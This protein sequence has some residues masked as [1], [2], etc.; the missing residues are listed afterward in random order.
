MDAHPLSPYINDFLNR[1]HLGSEVYYVGQLCDVWHMSTPQGDG[2]AFHLVCNGEAWVH[3]Q[4]GGTPIHLQ[5]GDIAFFPHYAAHRFSGKPEIPEQDFDYSCPALV[6]RHAPGTGMLCGHLKLP[7]HIRRLLLASFPEFMLIRPDESQTGRQLR[8]LI[9]L[10]SLEAEHNDIGVTAVLNHLSD[11]LFLLIIRHT[12]QALPHLSPLLAALSDEH[13]RLAMLPFIEQP[14]ATWSVESLA[15]LACL[16]RSTYTERFSRMV[17]M[18]PMEFVTNWRMQLAVGL[19]T[20]GNLSILDVALRC[21]YESDVAFRKA[22]KRV[23]GTTPGK[24][25][26]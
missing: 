15:K 1:L 22:F 16:S 2:S 26:S 9:E 21:G 23:I 4:D 17:K 3:M 12:L 14:E 11:A 7:P 8:S 25:R 6:D 13:L 20:Q 24:A 18:S 19:L 5:D 10:M